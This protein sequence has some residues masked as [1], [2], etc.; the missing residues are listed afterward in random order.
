MGHTVALLVDRKA[1]RH[2][3]RQTDCVSELIDLADGKITENHLYGTYSS[4]TSRQKGEQTQ[5]QTDRLRE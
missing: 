1:N 5:R 4:I 3:D 2:K